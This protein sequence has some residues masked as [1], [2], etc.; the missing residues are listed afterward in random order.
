MM[1]MV[2]DEKVKAAVIAAGRDQLR[3]MHWSHHITEYQAELTD[4]PM[5]WL[6]EAMLT[7]YNKA[8]AEQVTMVQ[9]ESPPRERSAW[10]P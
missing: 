4:M 5:V 8:M 9:F 7:A 6:F 3:A 2:M 10:N 1:G